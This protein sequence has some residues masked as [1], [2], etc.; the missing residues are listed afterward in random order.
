MILNA[1]QDDQTWS[2]HTD[3]RPTMLSLLG[4]RDSY[5]HDGRVLI[6][7]IEK[8]AQPVKLR[9]HQGTLRIS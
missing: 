3:V 1:G 9:G 5:V 4:L 6:E 8:N 2:D 7:A